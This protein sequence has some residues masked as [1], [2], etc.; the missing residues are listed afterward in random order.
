MGRARVVLAS[1]PHPH[2]PA[3]ALSLCSQ[4][5][6]APTSQRPIP[7]PFRHPRYL[8]IWTK[9]S[10]FPPDHDKGSQQSSPSQPKGRGEGQGKSEVS[11]R[12]R[13]PGNSSLRENI[14]HSDPII[15]AKVAH[16]RRLEAETKR[17]GAPKWQLPF[18]VS[19]GLIAVCLG[20]S[21]WLLY[22]GVLPLVRRSR[23]YGLLPPASAQPLSSDGT[24]STC[25]AACGLSV[26]GDDHNG[27]GRIG[28]GSGGTPPAVLFMGRVWHRNCL[29][30]SICQRKLAMKRSQ[31]LGKEFASWLDNNETVQA[32]MVDRRPCCAQCYLTATAPSCCICG[33]NPLS[34]VGR[35]AVPG[36]MVVGR[37]GEVFCAKHVEFSA[38]FS[39]EK[40]NRVSHYCGSCQ[41]PISPKSTGGGIR[42]GDGRV[43]CKPCRRQAIVGSHNLQTLSREVVDDLERVTGLDFGDLIIPVRA[44][45]RGGFSSWTSLISWLRAWGTG[46]L[47]E[48]RWRTTEGMTR[49][50]EV[51]H[52]GRVIDEI[53]ILDGL[54]YLHAAKVLAHEHGHGFLWLQAGDPRQQ[55]R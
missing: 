3:A 15:N 20:L 50:R 45:E 52:L 54:P 51:A 31:I 28:L 44:V 22:W 36:R 2:S 27:D 48:L 35:S 16:M 30:C 46:A 43:I 9:F 25:C 41:Y 5:A 26:A 38:E 18:I 47:I 29:K 49:R 39:G 32:L 13:G 42:Y 21:G 6:I 40:R 4:L 37:M 10:I 14:Y 34:P 1:A 19:G 17:Y 8:S 24:L 53:M 33:S 55:N 7:K 23:V 11:D 12:Y